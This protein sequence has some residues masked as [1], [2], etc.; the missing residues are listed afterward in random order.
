[1][2]IMAGPIVRRPC[3]TFPSGPGR[4]PN[5]TAPKA[6]LQKSISTA[7]SRHTSIGIITDELSGIGFTLLIMVSSEAI[8]YIRMDE[9]VQ[10]LV[11]RC[12][13][14]S[15]QPLFCC[16]KQRHHVVR[17][18]TGYFRMSRLE[19]RLTNGNRRRDMQLEWALETFER[20]RV[21]RRW[22]RDS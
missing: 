22:P 17:Q 12:R 7:T 16:A 9:K 20:P 3:T 19:P 15:P 6:V 13:V 5:S 2:M 18:T 10:H 14:V 21:G 4:R 1:M 8:E 11:G